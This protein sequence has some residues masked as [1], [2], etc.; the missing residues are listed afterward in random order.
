MRWMSLA[1]CFTLA[2]ALEPTP[3][4]AQ[5]VPADFN[6][7]GFS[8]LAVGAPDED[9][10]AVSNAGAVNVIYGSLDGLSSSGSQFWHQNSPGVTDEAEEFDH[11][12]SALAARDFNEDG[13]ADLAVG[14]PFESAGGAV[15]VLYG[16]TTGLSAA[17]DQLWHQ[18]SPG[19]KDAVEAGDEFGR[20]LAAGNL[21]GDGFADLAVG[22]PLESV[23]AISA[24][25]AVNVIYGSANGLS[26][27]FDQFW[28]QDRPDVRDA[29]ETSDVFG[30]SLVAADFGRGSPA[31]LAVGVS[32]EKVGTVTGGAVTVLYG[33][34]A[35]LSAAGNQIWH[36][37]SAGVRESAE[38]GDGFGSALAGADFG[39]S[40]QADLAVGVPG[41][42][43]N[44][45]LDAG[46]V[47][48]LYGASSGLAAA[49]NQLWHQDREGVKE[50]AE[51]EFF[52][53]TLAA[54]NFGQGARAELAV[55][56]PSETVGDLPNAG[57]VNVLY[58]TA[59]GLSAA[60]DQ[61]WH[62]RRIAGDGAEDDDSFGGALA[63]SS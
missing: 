28:H 36:Q 53:S 19:V 49:G 6:G 62:Q 34:P 10:G 16:S 29:A 14:V 9:I 60:F 17:G 11:F 4:A 44:L 23:G 18:D 63:P 61:L 52:G 8:D 25:G 39:S 56:V 54:A 24:A 21:N 46:A 30:I 42:D 50:T 15:N 1:L 7:D 47:N 43:L 27:D 3:A 37:D 20:A 55:G 58:G 41:E 35:G 59:S 22:V 31:D 57:A 2:A 26:A 51:E 32:G 13:F 5:N 12:G 33:S 45:L 40:S 48:V 38:E